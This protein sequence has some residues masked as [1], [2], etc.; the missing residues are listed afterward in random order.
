MK[1]KR[2]T[3]SIKELMTDD[4]T[5]QVDLER[6]PKYG[7]KKLKFSCPLSPYIMW[8]YELIFASCPVCSAQRDMPSCVNCRYKE[9]RQGRQERKKQEKTPIVEVKREKASIPKIGKTYH[10]K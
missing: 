1:D 5:Q 2:P 9:G 3:H 4:E 10:S 6:A 7:V 8:H